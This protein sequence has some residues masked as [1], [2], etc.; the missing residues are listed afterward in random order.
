MAYRLAAAGFKV[1]VLERGK[2][3]PPGSFP[4]SPHDMKR[5]F[6]DPSE[7]LYGL[8]NLWS[9]RHLGAIVASGLGGGSLIYA[10]VLI[11]KPRPWFVQS[12]RDQQHGEF[13]PVTYE[14]LEPHYAAAEQM[15]GA[16]RFPFDEP[17]YRDTPKTAEF[18]R[19]AESLGLTW[20]LPNLAVAFRSRS[21]ARPRPGDVVHE[22]DGPNLHGATRLTCRLVGE[23]D[24]GCNYGSKNTLDLTYLSRAT[25]ASA[26][27]RCL[28]EVQ[29]FRRRRGGGYEID[30]VT[31]PTDP[32]VRSDG[33]GRRSEMTSVSA[34]LLILSAGALGTPYLLLRNRSAFPALSHR[35]GTRFSGNGDLLTFALGARRSGDGGWT[36]VLLDAARGPVI[37]STVAVGDELDGGLNRGR[38]FYV[39]DAGYPHFVNW[40]LQTVNVPGALGAWLRV[41]RKL[42]VKWLSSEPETDIGAEASEL[43]GNTEL[44]SSLLPLLGMGRDV[45]DGRMR[46]RDRKLDIDWRL[47]ASRPYFER[48]RGTMRSIATELG[49]SFW[50]NPLW[51]L[52]RVI[53]VHPLG[54]CPMGRDA[55]EGV[56]DAWGQVFNYEGLYVADG[57]VM[58]GPVGPNPSLTIAALAER[59]ASRIIAT[60]QPGAR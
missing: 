16:E 12:D 8:F 33:P 35:L 1:L 36:P 18:R 48:V 31:H 9:F 13:W 24:V 11:R 6:W 43:F 34:S 52:S 60:R 59:F 23:C 57:S 7:G 55:S 28:S 10:N 47:A 29:R 50:D 37:T 42:L 25:D 45:P 2:S 41:G 4:R 54:G 56:V 32:D 26:E 5:N 22:P 39:Q 17:P 27:I 44:S 20:E 49:A 15:L 40:M 51:H 3:Y 19:A 38:G 46:L 30:F 53:T 14:D 21:G 58:P